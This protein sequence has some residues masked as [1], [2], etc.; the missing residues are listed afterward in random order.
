[1]YVYIYIYVCVTDGGQVYLTSIKR[2]TMATAS[3]PGRSVHCRCTSLGPN[4]S[5]P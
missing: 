3:V 5:I 2:A 4:L 1:M